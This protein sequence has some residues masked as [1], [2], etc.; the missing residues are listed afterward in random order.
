MYDPEATIQDADIE[1]A[2]YA[3]EARAIDIARSRGECVHSSVVGRSS[4]GEVYYP[5]QVGLAPGQFRCT[6]GCGRLF[7]DEAAHNRAIWE[8]IWG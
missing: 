6:D 5:E 2:E 3:R 4:T 8:V 7:E 1:M